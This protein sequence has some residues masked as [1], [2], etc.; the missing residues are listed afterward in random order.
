VHADATADLWTTEDAAV[1]KLADE[2]HARN[3]VDD[4]QWAELKQL[5]GDE[6]LLELLMLA[7]LYHAVSY[8]VN[9]ARI[10]HEA[11]APRFPAKP[12]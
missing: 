1:I 5:F 11:F 8:V 3:D 7:G 12:A 2:L 9:A 4:A 10:E 6:Q